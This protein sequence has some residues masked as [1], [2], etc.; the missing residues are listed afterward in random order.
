MDEYKE[1]VYKK[2][3]YLKNVNG[4]DISKQ[5]EIRKRL[6]CKP[7]KWFMETVAFDLIKHYPP[8]PPPYEII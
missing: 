6:Q 1:F 5:L 7:F 3:P 2:S 4:G 8:I